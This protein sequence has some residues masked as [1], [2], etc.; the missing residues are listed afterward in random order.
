ME[1]S[2]RGGQCLSEALRKGLSP[3]EQHDEQDEGQDAS[4][5]G[6]WEPI[7][8]VSAESEI[9]AKHDVFQSLSAEATA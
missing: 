7:S 6:G 3:D 8:R 4:H 9:N 5:A 1:A 2:F